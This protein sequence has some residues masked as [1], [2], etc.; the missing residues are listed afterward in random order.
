MTF[1]EYMSLLNP[2]MQSQVGS[3]YN[4][5]S[6]QRANAMRGGGFGGPF[7]GSTQNYGNGFIN[8]YRYSGLSVKESPGDKLYADIIRQSTRDYEEF[9][10]PQERRLLGMITSTGTT[11]LPEELERTRGAILGAAENVQGTS[12]RNAARLGIRNTAMDQN[13][14]TSTLVG[15]ANETRLRDVDRRLQM[16][17]GGLSGVSGKARSIG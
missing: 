10:A 7:G 16:I 2:E 11:F 6:V 4:T 15:G 3:Y 8:P 12:D 9:Y 17:T 1:D 13:N 14:I 5:G